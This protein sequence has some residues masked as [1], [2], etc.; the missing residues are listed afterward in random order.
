M[1][2]PVLPP[3]L[4]PNDIP[5]KLP[6]AKVAWVVVLVSVIFL[7]WT[8]NKP[9]P[10]GESNVVASESANDLAILK[11]QS[12]IVIGLMQFPM[13]RSEAIRNLEQLTMFASNPKSAAAVAIVNVFADEENGLAS[14]LK[15]LDKLDEM[16]A[17]QIAMVE[18]VRIGLEN[19]VTPEQRAGLKPELGW[20]ADLIKPE[21]ETEGDFGTSI[22]AEAIRSMI[23]MGVFICLAIFAFLTGLI[24]L[25]LFLLNRSRE[26]LKSKFCP[27]E[28]PQ[29]R[30]LFME[31]FAVYIGLM[32]LGHLLAS[33]FDSSIAM[34]FY[35][36]SFVLAVFWP[37][38]RGCSWIQFCQLIGWNRGKGFFRE[39]GAGILG[40]FGI[41]V[42]AGI[43]L[44]VT[45]IVMLIV[46]FVQSGGPPEAGSGA[47]HPIVGML[48]STDGLIG[49]LLLLFF[50]AGLAPFLEETMFRGALFRYFRHH[51]G[52]FLSAVVG[53]II[54][55]VIH[56]QG[57]VAVPAL[58][59]MGI[60]FAL[61]REWRD[62]LLASMTAHA[63]NN[64][65][66]VGLLLL[67]IS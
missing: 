63:I 27:G 59:A 14:G 66:I 37:K 6:G 22:K 16:N 42:I 30:H 8:A 55:A 56:P 46:S 2:D 48:D 39:I 61:L 49:K 60:G 13:Y 3:P 35:G 21:A 54:F 64:G 18:K 31:S 43:G 67:V 7:G 41:L 62:S 20:F 25:L 12:R 38:I 5:E 19:G 29:F 45:M 51:W 40:Y 24:L 15:I 4:H 17:D 11:L 26:N 10:G 47:T 1:P 44:T 53:G 33:F 36:L 57:L 9:L 34:V 50:A 58:A 32:A 52:F 28:A 65:V 23:I